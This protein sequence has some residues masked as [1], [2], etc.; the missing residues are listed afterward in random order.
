MGP[1]W[2]HHVIVLHV[3]ILLFLLHFVVVLHA[4]LL[5]FVLHCSFSC[6]ITLLFSMLHCSLCFDVP[7]TFCC[8]SCFV[9]ARCSSYFVVA[10]H[11]S[12]LFLLRYYFLLCYS[13]CFVITWCFVAPTSLLLHGVSPFF[14]ASLF[15]CPPRYLSTPY[16]FVVLMCFIVTQSSLFPCLDWSSPYFL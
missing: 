14:H 4:S 1:S 13:C 15:Y 3:L 11:A 9:V 12:L 6:F 7:P 16:C 10:L 8:S 2:P 5:L